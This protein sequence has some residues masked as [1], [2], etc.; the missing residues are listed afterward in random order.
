MGL[1]PGWEDALEKEMADPLQYSCLESSMDTGAWWATVHG[2]AE[3]DMTERMCTHVHTHTPLISLSVCRFCLA[4]FIALHLLVVETRS[5][6]PVVSD[7]LNFGT[8]LSAVT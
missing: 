2:I 4:L 8:C 6:S 1:I 7:I 5:L 3:S